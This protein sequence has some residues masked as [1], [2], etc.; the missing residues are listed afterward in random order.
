M[1]LSTSSL[2][3]QSLDDEVE[4][5]W[6]AY[7]GA[8]NRVDAE[9]QTR[10]AFKSLFAENTTKNYQSMSRHR[11]NQVH[12]F[13]AIGDE[14]SSKGF[15]MASTSAIHSSDIDSVDDHVTQ[16]PLSDLVANSS[17]EVAE[18]LK[19]DIRD[20]QDPFGLP[21]V[22]RSDALPNPRHLHAAQAMID[23]VKKVGQSRRAQTF[24]ELAHPSYT[25]NREKENRLHPLMAILWKNMARRMQT[26][27]A[28]VWSR[29]GPAFGPSIKWMDEGMM[30][31]GKHNTS[32]A[33]LDPTTYSL[34][35][36]VCREE[37]SLHNAQY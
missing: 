16:I 24:H 21:L 14:R 19:L 9:L 33:I 26:V 36:G 13:G 31:K 10:P 25:I 3:S 35:L 5:S 23:P 17:P 20:L 11:D 4:K 12:R 22:T 15:T 29:Q 2:L 18:H 1:K 30:R 28:Q 32:M 27:S 37:L 7:S 6:H 34:P 8:Q